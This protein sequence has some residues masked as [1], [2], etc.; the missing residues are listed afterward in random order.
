MA[1]LFTG[2]VSK[3][4]MN[5]DDCLNGRHRDSG[6]IGGDTP[7]GWHSLNGHAY[8]LAVDS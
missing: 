3:R 7:L 6:R 5:N 4:G 2:L 1:D 8:D